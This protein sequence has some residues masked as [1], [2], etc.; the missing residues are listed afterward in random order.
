MYI[1]HTENCTK[2]KHKSSVN[3]Y[4]VN[5]HITTHG[6]HV[7]AIANGAAVN[8]RIH[9]FFW[10][11]VFSRCM[12]KSGIAR[13]YFVSFLRNLHTVLHSGCDNLHSHQYCKRVPFSPHALQHVLLVGFLMMAILTG[14]RWYVTTFDLYFSDN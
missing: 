10:I 8:I 4:K 11:M 14:L 1:T 12:P 3:Y 5:T 6:F 7:L 13:S 9:V 2:H